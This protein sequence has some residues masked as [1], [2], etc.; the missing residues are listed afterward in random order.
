MKNIELAIPIDSEN[1]SIQKDEKK[2]IQC[3]YCRTTCENE[4][5]VARMYELGK[6][7]KPICIKCGQCANMCPNESIKEKMEYENVKRLVKDKTKKLLI[8]LMRCTL[9][10][11]LVNSNK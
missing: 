1:E 4:V 3:G 9:K 6:T 2:C 8:T 5:T 11:L 7:K 10:R